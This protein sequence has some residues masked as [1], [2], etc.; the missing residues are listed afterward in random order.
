MGR[1][2]IHC[3]GGGDGAAVAVAVAAVGAAVAVAVFAVEYAVILVPGMAAAGVVTWVLYRVAR[4]RTVAVW[5]G[6][7]SP[8]VTS[9]AQ[10]L[11]AL[12]GRTAPLAIE[13]R[14]VIPGV[15][16]HRVAED[17][18]RPVRETGHGQQ[19]RR[20]AVVKLVLVVEDDPPVT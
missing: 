2:E 12:E 18:A 14:H 9:R 20:V 5:H 15:G 13:S 17:H 10:A 1:C 3:P 7:Y 4:R 11:R 8:L 16:T 19:G 6:R